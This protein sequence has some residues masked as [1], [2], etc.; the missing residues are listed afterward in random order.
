MN[1]VRAALLG[2]LAMLVASGPALAQAPA[3]TV[4]SVRLDNGFT[5]LVR[6]NPVAPVVAVALL[7]RM[8]SRWET[9]ANAGISN[10]THA[11]MVKGTT[12]RSGSDL[13]ETVALLGGKIAAA[14]DVDYSGIQGTALA[15]Y[16]RELLEITAEMALSPRLAPE[17]VPREREWLTSRIQRRRDN[18]PSR[19]FDELYAALY[20][21]HPYGLRS[22][23]TRESLDRIDHAAIVAWYRAFYRPERMTLA[24]SGQ[25]SASEVI[26]EAQRL[27]GAQPTGTPTP[28]PPVPPPRAPAGRRVIQQEAQQTQILVGGLAPSLDHPD[29]A[30]VKVLSTILG[31]GMAGRLFVELRDKSALAYTAASY[32]DPVHESGAL[33]LYLGTAPQNAARA[34][35][36]LMREVARVRDEPV[37]ADEL[38]RAKGYLLGRYAM[39]R[40][41]NER[42]AWYLAFYA[43]EGVGLEYPA[44]YRARVEAVTAA[45]IQRVARTY[46]ASPTILILG[47]R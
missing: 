1:Q 46:L 30:A 12:K 22:L 17:D 11:V 36:A 24:V 44:R 5:V 23:G 35:S 7:V 16:W 2:V 37:P 15:R 43:V 40:R 38:A 26:A 42:I 10:F 29:H 19:A 41:T 31:G 14:G 45:D 28:D 4:R 18:A 3:E 34:E 9:P 25:V 32:Y 13:A 39:D 6:E 21:S 27:F 47:P 8:G 33:I 20:G